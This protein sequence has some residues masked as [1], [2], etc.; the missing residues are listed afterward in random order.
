M[1]LI[2]QIVYSTEI[3]DE[4]YEDR[5]CIG[6]TQQ[7]RDVWIEQF[8]AGPDRILV[9]ASIHGTERIGTPLLN[10][11]IQ[12]LMEHPTLLQGKTLYL[13]RDANP[14]GGVFGL[15]G[16]RDN[17]DINRNFPTDNFGRGWF[18]G[19]EPLLAV[20]AQNLMVL[21]SELEPNRVLSIHQPLNGIDYDGPSKA[22]A[23]C[24][25]Q[26]TGLRIHRLGARSGSLGTFVGVE[27]KTP[28]VTLE[29]PEFVQNR[30]P[31]WIWNKYGPL[32][33]LFLSYPDC[34][35]QSVEQ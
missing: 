27:L 3:Q 23:E 11:W 13:L 6:Q 4:I 5:F 24:L 30:S 35:V 12:F 8:G 28:V 29:I 21:L 2:Q 17:I 14:D 31:E 22:L 33:L 7:G 10:Q 25:A 34:D 9:I 15:R 20:E 26:H 1:L 32:L 19:E 18:N 16:N